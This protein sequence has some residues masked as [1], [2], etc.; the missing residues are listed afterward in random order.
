MLPRHWPLPAWSGLL[1]TLCLA[2]CPEGRLGL[3]SPGSPGTGTPGQS[4]SVSLVGASEAPASPGEDTAPGKRSPAPDIPAALPVFVPEEGPKAIPY[5]SPG[6]SGLPI[7]QT[8]PL[9][10][11]PAAW[12][13]EQARSWWVTCPA[14]ATLMRI[15]RSP[16]RPGGAWFRSYRLA[17]PGASAPRPG[18]IAIAGAPESD[19]PE[20]VYVS[21]QDA[22]GDWIL[23][24][25]PLGS[26]VRLARLNSPVVAIAPRS[27]GL[28]AVCL[29]DPPRLVTMRPDGDLEAGSVQLATHATW[30]VPGR[31]ESE[32]GVWIRVGDGLVWIKEGRSPGQWSL[33]APVTPDSWQSL[34]PDG[35][36]ADYRPLQGNLLRV[37]LET[38]SG[39]LE[40]LG[41]ATTA[42]RLERQTFPASLPPPW[43]GITFAQNGRPW[44]ARGRILSLVEDTENAFD[45]SPGGEI[46]GLATSPDGS[47]WTF[48][49]DPA[50]ARKWSN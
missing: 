40:S 48:E 7:G 41:L 27:D 9:D 11:V 29:D 23:S 3:L 44:I 21:P 6:R 45:L 14:S 16:E 42:G 5:D 39:R 28:L 20:R 33:P 19:R 37:L 36:L 35:R 22:S 34:V 13:M 30:M 25:T 50:V 43:T 1:I 49:R 47:I 26:D 8:V 15:D 17:L 24:M 38:P 2:G 12:T 46:V 18:G 31:I 32:P 10:S 4:P